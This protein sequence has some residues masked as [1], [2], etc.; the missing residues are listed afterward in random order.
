MID[1]R[2]EDGL[3][4]WRLDVFSRAPISM[5]A[6]SDLVPPLLSVACMVG[7]EKEQTYFVIERAVHSVLLCR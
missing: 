1:V 3:R 7:E 2:E 4:E 5:A 6:C